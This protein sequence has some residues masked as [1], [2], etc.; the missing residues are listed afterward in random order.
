MTVGET[1][2]AYSSLPAVQEYVLPA[3]TFTSVTQPTILLPE[4]GQ[5]IYPA[6]KQ[7]SLQ[8]HLAQDYDESADI[9]AT[10][11]DGSWSNFSYGVVIAFFCGFFGLLC[12]LC[13]EEKSSYL[14]GWVVGFVIAA[15][16]G[17][18]VWILV[19]TLA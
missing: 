11:S 17:F 18:I 6:Q 7:E 13:V 15:V 3:P 16:V 10:P 5:P 8:Q 12:L 2:S 14:K 19:F 1:E 4:I 9:F